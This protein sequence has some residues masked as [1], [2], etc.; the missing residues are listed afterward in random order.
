MIKVKKVNQRYILTWI[1]T[2]D[3]VIVNKTHTHTKHIFILKFSTQVHRCISYKTIISTKI[4]IL[5]GYIGL[6][7]W[8]TSSTG[9]ECPNNT[10]NKSRWIAQDRGDDKLHSKSSNL[11]ALFDLPFTPSS[12][13]VM[14]SIQCILY[15]TNISFNFPIFHIQTMP[16]LHQ[17]FPHTRH[18][19]IITL[20][21]RPVTPTPS[22]SSTTMTRRTHFTTKIKFHFPLLHNCW[23]FRATG[24]EIEPARLAVVHEPLHVLFTRV[25]V[26]RY[27]SWWDWHEL[28]AAFCVEWMEQSIGIDYCTLH[29]KVV[30]TNAAF[31]TWPYSYFFAS[32][33]FEWEFVVFKS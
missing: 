17:H 1:L 6:Y 10:C 30:V 29:V 23:Q 5:S 8:S 28:E 21:F 31:V 7:S 19:H 2:L 20:T 4:N 18:M 16:I 32:V 12:S 13:T 22:F 3:L 26:T 24:V 11:T 33:T 9:H 14:C 27:V 25:A 15:T